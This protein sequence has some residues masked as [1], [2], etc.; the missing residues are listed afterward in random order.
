MG[1][2]RERGK[3][4]G[5]EHIHLK[6]LMVQELASLEKALLKVFRPR[7]NNITLIRQP[8]AHTRK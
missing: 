3:S 1:G 2:V 5:E 8:L 6:Y 7:Q 4:V